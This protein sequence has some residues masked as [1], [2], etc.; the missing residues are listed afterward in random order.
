MS[1]TV[2]RDQALRFLSVWKGTDPSDLFYKELETGTVFVVDYGELI[3]KI[4]MATSPVK[5]ITW[6]IEKYV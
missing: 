3:Y 6:S 2:T 4:T 1:L 5:E